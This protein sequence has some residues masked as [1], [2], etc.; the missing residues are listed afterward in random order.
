MKESLMSMKHLLE[1]SIVAYNLKGTHQ[2]TTR[3]V[4]EAMLLT[5]PELRHVEHCV[6]VWSTVL[7]EDEIESLIAVAAS[8]LPRLEVCSG[9]ALVF[10]GMFETKAD[11]KLNGERWRLHRYDA[12][13]FPSNPH[14]HNFRQNVKL[15]LG[16]GEYYRARRMMGKMHR[17]DLLL[18]RARF[19]KF[20]IELPSLSL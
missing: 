8:L 7:D 15:H 6:D 13:P 10:T 4:T 18:L 3:D 9:R 5:L 11:V 1:R 19:A 20:E 2:L 16:N 14:A 17:K 12:D